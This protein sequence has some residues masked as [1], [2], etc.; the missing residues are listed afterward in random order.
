MASEGEPSDRPVV[1]VPGRREFAVRPAL[2]SDARSFLALYRQV[3]SEGP[4]RQTY[5]SNSSG[6]AD[7]EGSL[8]NHTQ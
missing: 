2:P 6:G 3:V 1:A 7:R 4:V 5:G 8:I